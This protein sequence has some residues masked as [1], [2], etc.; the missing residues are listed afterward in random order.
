[1]KLLY[2]FKVS[3]RF[4]GLFLALQIREWGFERRKLTFR[5][6]C[7]RP[8]AHGTPRPYLL[9]VDREVTTVGGGISFGAGGLRRTGHAETIRE[10]WAGVKGSAGG[11][12]GV[13]GSRW[14]RGFSP[15]AGAAPFTVSGKPFLRFQKPF[16]VFRS[17]RGR[18]PFSLRRRRR[19]GGGS[20][21]GGWSRRLGFQESKRDACT[22]FLFQESKRDACTTFLFESKRDAGTTFRFQ[23]RR[24]AG[25][26]FD[27]LGS[28]SGRGGR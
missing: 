21:P 27:G 14:A 28:R 13:V 19:G 16:M 2:S 20:A 6:R 4:A 5:T 9:A 10:F 3:N 8:I 23:S 7:R 18:R 15:S 26:S 11:R 24:D 22:T 1:M 25:A 17:R 12:G